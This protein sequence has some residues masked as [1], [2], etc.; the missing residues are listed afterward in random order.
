MAPA[1]TFP[2]PGLTSLSSTTARQVDQET[3]TLDNTVGVFA[4]EELAWRDRVF[5]TGGVRLDNNSAFGGKFRNVYYPKVSGCVGAQRGAVL[6]PPERQFAE[7]ARRLRRVGAG[8]APVLRERDVHRG[9]RSLRRLGDAVQLSEIRISVRSAATR[10]SSASTLGLF[11]DRAGIEFTYYFG[12]TKDAILQQ[13]LPPS[14]GYPGTQFV[15][16]GALTK[17][18]F[19]LALHGTPYQ[20]K[21]TEWTLGLNMSTAD[22][23]VT[24]LNGAAYLQASTNVRHVVGFPGGLVVR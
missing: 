4:Q 15:N 23:K 2:A 5:I 8:A 9:A 10:R 19:E 24:N 17:H 11:H 3:D 6:P 20:T 16:A 13:Q 7:A 18:G 22:N 12:G 1:Q 21:N 14:L